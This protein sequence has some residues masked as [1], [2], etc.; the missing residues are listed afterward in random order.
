MTRRRIIWILVLIVLAIMALSVR[1]LNGEHRQTGRM[2][3]TQIP[4]CNEP[5]A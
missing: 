5:C 4:A 1:T 3:T 2:L